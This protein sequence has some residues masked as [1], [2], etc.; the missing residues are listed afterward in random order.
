MDGALC[1]P[2]MSLTLGV[3]ARSAPVTGGP[4]QHRAAYGEPRTSILFPRSR[5]LQGALHPRR[6]RE[7]KPRDSPPPGRCSPDSRLSG[8]RGGAALRRPYSVPQSLLGGPPHAEG[9]HYFNSIELAVS[10]FIRGAPP[11]PRRLSSRH[12]AGD[13]ASVRA[14]DR[15]VEGSPATPDSPAGGVACWAPRR[16]ELQPQLQS[17][18][19]RSSPSGVPRRCT[20]VA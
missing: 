17:W 18:T 6:A 5:C 4:G 10:P 3:A 8:V 15:D 13:P 12:V 19:I 7:P 2:P 16:W 20:V 14:P 1:S 11:H 9:T